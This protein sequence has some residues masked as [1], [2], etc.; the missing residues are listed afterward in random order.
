MLCR[1]FFELLL[2]YQYWAARAGAP[3]ID[4]PLPPIRFLIAVAIHQ[5]IIIV[6]WQRHCHIILH[7]RQACQRSE[8]HQAPTLSR[9]CLGMVIKPKTRAGVRRIHSY[10]PGTGVDGSDPTKAHLP[11][12]SGTTLALSH[13]LAGLRAL[14]ALPT[15]GHQ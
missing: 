12:C 2:V 7:V 6:V 13:S 11:P 5:H 14:V 15:L 3:L 4:R 9:R 10:Q 8:T 1:E